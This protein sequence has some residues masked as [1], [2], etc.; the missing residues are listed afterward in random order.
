M[1]ICGSNLQNYISVLF[2]EAFFWFLASFM[3]RVGWRKGFKE[4]DPQKQCFEWKNAFRRIIQVS[5]AEVRIQSPISHSRNLK[6]IP[7]TINTNRTMYVCLFICLKS[8]T[9]KIIMI[10]LSIKKLSCKKILILSK[11]N[12]SKY[13]KLI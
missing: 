11:L 5:T 8:G 10:Y 3:L 1:L 13:L 7:G 4:K 2:N 9:T 12:L 6:M